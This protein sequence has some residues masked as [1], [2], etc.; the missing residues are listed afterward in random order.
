MSQT[1]FN[2]V[3]PLSWIV[4]AALALWLV[5]SAWR[6]I[7]TG[8]TQFYDVL[9]AAILLVVINRLWYGVRPLIFGARIEFMGGTELALWVSSGIWS[10]V[11]AVVIYSTLK[12]YE[13]NRR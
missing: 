11:S 8:R 9:R 5:P 10:I 4:W 3:S 6:V 1:V 2:L 13:K 7:V 12:A